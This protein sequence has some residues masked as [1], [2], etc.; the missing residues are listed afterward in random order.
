MLPEGQIPLVYLF[1]VRND[2]ES[3]TMPSAFPPH[4]DHVL[5][6]RVVGGVE[7]TGLAD[8]QSSRKKQVQESEVPQSDES[9]V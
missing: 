3:Q 4:A 1:T 7:R 2:D 8:A 5:V 9:A 6:Q